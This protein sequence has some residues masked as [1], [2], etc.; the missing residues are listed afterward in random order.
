MKLTSECGQVRCKF[1]ELAHAL[2][3]SVESD[4]VRS[5]DEYPLGSN[6]LNSSLG[7][8][9]EGHNNSQRSTDSPLSRCESVCVSC[10]DLPGPVILI[11]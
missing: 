7:P 10:G 8:K 1:R 6:Q 11:A 9:S 3:R 4:V 2:F 5:D